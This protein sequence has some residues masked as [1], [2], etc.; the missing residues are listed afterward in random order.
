MPSLL[1]RV[2]DKFFVSVVGIFV[3][4]FEDDDEELEEGN[5]SEELEEGNSSAEPN[6]R[7]KRGSTRTE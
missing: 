6:P 5:S 2:A 3:F 7:R 1:E 4:V